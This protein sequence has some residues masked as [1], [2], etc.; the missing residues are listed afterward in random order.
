MKTAHRTSSPEHR[1]LKEVVFSCSATG[2]PS[3]T[4][5]WDLSDS[6]FAISQPETTTMANR[7]DTFTSSRNIS[8]RVPAG[9]RG[10]VD[11]LLNR[12]MTGERQEKIPSTFGVGPKDKD[13]FLTDGGM[14]VNYFAGRDSCCSDSVAAEVVESRSGRGISVCSA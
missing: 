4:I 6:S 11:C 3:P 5:E 13:P 9:W 14:Q 12:G 8:L 1:G 10:H 2:R 7:D